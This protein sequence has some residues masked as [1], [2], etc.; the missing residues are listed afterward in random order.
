[1]KEGEE[2]EQFISSRLS[3]VHLV[4][5]AGTEQSD[6]SGSEDYGEDEDYKPLL[7]YSKQWRIQRFINGGANQWITTFI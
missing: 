2:L 1:M 5:L 6:S 7:T 3:D 4:N